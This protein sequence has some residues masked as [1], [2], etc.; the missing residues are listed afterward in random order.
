M[1]LRE[2]GVNLITDPP[3]GARGRLTHPNPN[4][5]KSKEGIA[6]FKKVGLEYPE[7]A[8][9]EHYDKLLLR[10]PDGKAR[11]PVCLL[12]VIKLFHE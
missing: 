11:P 6:E 8:W 5:V 3:K 10:T 2:T 7:S 9:D 12:E 4:Y 1:T